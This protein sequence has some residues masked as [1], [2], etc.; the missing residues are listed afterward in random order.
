M[1]LVGFAVV[2]L[3]LCEHFCFSELTLNSTEDPGTW[4][5]DSILQ[6]NL[7]DAPGAAQTVPTT[8]ATNQEFKKGQ[9]IYSIRLYIWMPF[10]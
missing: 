4:T 1:L 8:A 5:T 7:S 10:K 2:L 6:T 9:L 3:V